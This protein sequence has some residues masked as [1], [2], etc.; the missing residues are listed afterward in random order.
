MLSVLT[1]SLYRLKC[2]ELQCLSFPSFTVSME[3]MDLETVAAAK[4]LVRL[5]AG[6]SRNYVH[7]SEVEVESKSTPEDHLADSS[8][9]V[10]HLLQL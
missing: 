2:S 5:A 9:L 1:R 10:T 3:G 4:R 7:K 8:P 6:I